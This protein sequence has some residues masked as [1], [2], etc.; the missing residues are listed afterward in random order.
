MTCPIMLL[1]TTRSPR[2]EVGDVGSSVLEVS[3]Q[4]EKPSLSPRVPLDDSTEP[5]PCGRYPARVLAMVV[6]SPAE[7]CQ[8]LASPSEQ[9]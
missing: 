1:V 7:S 5:G 6:P 4:P 8:V 3:R 2:I 9:L